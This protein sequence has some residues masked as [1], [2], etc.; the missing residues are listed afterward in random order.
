MAPAG[1]VDLANRFVDM[2]LQRPPAGWARVPRWTSSNRSTCSRW[3][4]EH[5]FFSKSTLPRS[6]ACTPFCACACLCVHVATLAQ[7]DYLVLPT[8]RF[9]T[10]LSKRA[11]RS[12]S[13]SCTVA[14]TIC[15]S[16]QSLTNAVSLSSCFDRVSP[17]LRASPPARCVAGAS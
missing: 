8:R 13:K 9:L 7:P 12:Y 10:W 2:S 17:R 6:Y 15:C 3:A 1:I 4:I 16:T 11:K 14:T 5:R